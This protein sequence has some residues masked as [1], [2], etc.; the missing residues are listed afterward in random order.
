MA[1]GAVS[2]AMFAAVVAPNAAL[3][4]A[5]DTSFPDLNKGD[6]FYEELNY[7]VSEGVIKGLPD[8]TIGSTKEITRAE[9]TV[10]LA[11][12][13]D[14][15]H[16]TNYDPGFSDVEEGKWYY[17]SIAALHE[18]DVVQGDGS[19]D[20]F[21]PNDTITRS[22]MASLFTKAFGFEENVRVGAS[23]EDVSSSDWFAGYVGALKENGVTNGKSDTEF[24]PEDIITRGEVAAFIY[25]SLGV[26]EE[27]V[28]E[29]HHVTNSTVEINGE[30]YHIS[31]ELTSILNASNQA[32]LENA[33]ISFESEN[34]TIT[35]ITYLEITNAGEAEAD[36]DEFA[37]H[38]VLDGQSG[39][40]HG[41]VK[42]AADY[43]SLNN[44]TIE[45]NV[46]IGHQV[47]NSFYSDGLVVEGKTTIS[48]EDGEAQAQSLAQIAEEDKT[49]V[50]FENATLNEVEVSKNNVSVESKGNT[51][52]T[53]LVI[54]SNAS[55]TASEDVVIPKVTLRNG[56]EQVEI[57]A[58]VTEL[59]IDSTTETTLTGEATIDTVKVKNT[60]K[61][62][63]KT[64]GEIKKLETVNEE[65][66]VNIGEET[67]VEDITL[68]EGSD[69]EDVV[70]NYDDVKENIEK[71]DGEDNPDYKDSSSGSRGSSGGSGGN[72]G[73]NDGGSTGDDVKEEFLD[74]LEDVVQNVKTKNVEKIEIDKDGTRTHINT[75]LSVPATIDKLVSQVIEVG[76]GIFISS[77]DGI[78]EGKITFDIVDRVET[79]TVA[80][81]IDET[82]EVGSITF[83][84]SDEEGFIISTTIPF[85]IDG[86]EINLNHTKVLDAANELL[87]GNYDQLKELESG[88]SKKAI[89]DATITKDGKEINLNGD[90]VFTIAE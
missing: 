53:G 1:T 68:P 43:V 21:R 33:L 52:L 29:I 20:K 62:N 87:S 22:E 72:G 37:G 18:A 45:G 81:T 89:Y 85:T 16:D 59:E 38:L 58:T 54:K 34:S 41:D 7:L 77:Q 30:T 61:V 5:A 55:I 82:E 60:A 76:E 51:S 24:A 80:F 3:V 13:L 35:K 40:I 64:T 12:V 8:G 50:V 70:E 19:T 78:E 57:H 49:R 32:I 25:R 75:T 10:M 48:D 66:K 73:S 67:K 11:R 42:V 6:M 23:F 83:S 9:A 14:L 44:L 31:E 69:V 27:A 2:A 84:I 15:D 47:E 90:L 79:G 86:N 88:Y 36:G 46:A 26:D 65:A 71:V 28:S 39:T 56:S 4:Q 17:N 63:L 74:D